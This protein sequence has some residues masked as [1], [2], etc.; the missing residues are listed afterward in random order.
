MEEKYKQVIKAEIVSSNKT[1]IIDIIYELI[2]EKEVDKKTIRNKV[3]KSEFNTLYRT[4]M[5]VMDIYTSLSDDF[6]ISLDTVRYII[7]NL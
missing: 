4:S 3:I 5:P 7:R 6:N 1:D 2:V